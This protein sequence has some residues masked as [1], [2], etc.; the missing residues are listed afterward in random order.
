MDLHDALSQLDHI[1][2]QLAHSATFRGYRSLPAAL[3]ATMA[4]LAATAQTLWFPTVAQTPLQFVLLWVSVA[5]VCGFLQLLEIVV[6]AW[7]DGRQVTTRLTVR[8]LEMLVPCLVSGACLTLALVCVAPDSLWLLPGLW[9][10][11]LSLG[12]FASLPVLPRAL[13]L[14]AFHYFLCGIGCLVIF[15]GPWAFSPWSMALTFG[16][17]QL[18]ASLLLYFTQER[19][20]D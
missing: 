18:L 3:T 8:A 14:V 13:S 17:G 4:L 11:L 12:I 7:R 10:L 6:R 15:R 20:H 19:C 5:V 16:G 2:K 9:S 1:Q